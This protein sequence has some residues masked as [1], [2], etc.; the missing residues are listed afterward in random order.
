MTRRDSRKAGL[1]GSNKKQVGDKDRTS[2]TIADEDESAIVEQ[3]DTGREEGAIGDDRNQVVETS[4]GG[5]RI[6]PVGDIPSPEVSLLD[7]VSGE[8]LQKFES[9]FFQYQM[10]VNKTTADAIN[11]AMLKLRKDV[12]S[13][14]DRVSAVERHHSNDK[15]DEKSGSGEQALVDRSCEECESN[16]P[17]GDQ[18]SQAC[19]R[20]FTDSP[21]GNTG[22][23][24]TDK[25]KFKIIKDWGLRYAGNSK[26]IPVERFLFR[27]ETLQKR[28]NISSEDLYANFHL[29]LEGSAQDWFWLF[30]EEHSEGKNVGFAELRSALLNQFRKADC[31]EEIRQAMNERKQEFSET[32]D[33]FYASI[34]GRAFT[35]KDR[36]P[37]LSLV[38]LMRRNLKYKIKN[39]IFGCHIET[40]QQLKEECRRAAKHLKEQ[41]QKFP[42]RKL[43]DEVEAEPHKDACDAAEEVSLEA[44]D[45]RDRKAFHRTES[46]RGP[47]EARICQT[48]KK[49]DTTE[50]VACS[51]KF[52]DLVCF[53]CNEMRT[54]FVLCDKCKQE[55]HMAG[56]NSGK[57]RQ[58]QPHPDRNKNSDNT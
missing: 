11:E 32:F 57:N 15:L 54:R 46:N 2:K 27:V 4:R 29:L 30:M 19:R 56:G 10:D 20:L 25:L 12:R 34:K 6:I 1:H 24:R 49:V 17:S 3:E 23:A 33:E 44:L 22:V 51:S 50:D 28:H 41:E 21:D 43:V 42:R 26:S 7:K 13:L 18:R 16:G 36:M 37:E 14:G 8:L 45:G 5:Q 9:M 31:D 55:N 40:L 47:A 52:H 38:N 53:K 48:V 35:M 58:N 39:L